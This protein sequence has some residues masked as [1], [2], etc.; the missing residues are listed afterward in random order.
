MVAIMFWKS[1][2]WTGCYGFDSKLGCDSGLRIELQPWLQPWSKPP[3]Q[4]VSGLRPGFRSGNWSGLRSQPWIETLKPTTGFD[5]FKKSQPW[6][7]SMVATMVSVS[8][9]TSLKYSLRLS[10]GVLL[11]EGGRLFHFRGSKCERM[12]HVFKTCQKSRSGKQ[13]DKICCKSGTHLTFI[14]KIWT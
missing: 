1:K 10:E 12:N 7:F 11:F 3:F 5:F 14:F 13:V 2:P 6:A 9:E 4:N 8:I